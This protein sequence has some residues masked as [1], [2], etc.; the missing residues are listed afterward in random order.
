MSDLWLYSELE[1]TKREKLLAE[2]REGKLTAYRDLAC[3]DEAYG[4]WLFLVDLYLRR[5]YGIT[6]SDL[7][8]FTW[9][10]EYRNGASPR[11]AATDALEADDLG[12]MMVGDL[13]RLQAAETSS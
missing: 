6:H 3:G 7:A 12:Q 5:R 13:E 10:D 4:A 9:R 11:S 1:P 2:V 8:D